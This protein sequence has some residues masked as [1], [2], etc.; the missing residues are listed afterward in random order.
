MLII[1]TD[2]VSHTWEGATEKDDAR[3]KQLE[4]LGYK[5]LRFDDYDVMK[6]IVYVKET[7][8]D[9]IKAHPPCPPSKGDCSLVTL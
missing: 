5:V 3:T 9:W 2:G 7:I 4:A 1:E 8:E 6:N